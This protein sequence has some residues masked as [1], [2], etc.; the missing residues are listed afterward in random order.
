MFLGVF[1]GSGG[2]A[3]LQQLL[4]RADLGAWGTLALILLI[5]FLAGFVLDVI[6]IMLILVPLA[7]PIVSNLGFD[8]IWFS[9][10]LLL[11]M[12][13]SLLTPPMAGAIFYFRAIAPSEIMLRD[14][15][16]GVVPFI[17]LHFAVLALVIAF[18]ALALWLPTKLLGFD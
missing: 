7:M 1:A 2:I 4:A 16:R 10:M 17:A 18:P 9:I 8:P 15:Y 5:T 3:D 14:M 6:S 12:Q 11:M 13:T